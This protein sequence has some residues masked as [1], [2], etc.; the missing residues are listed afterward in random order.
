L[1][2]DDFNDRRI[3]HY[4]RITE[5]E[6]LRGT[7]L[8]ERLD[9]GDRG[10]GRAAREM[11]V[12]YGRPTIS[13]WGGRQ[14]DRGHYDY[15]DVSNDSLRDHGR[16]V[17]AEYEKPRVH[18]IPDWRA[19]EDPYHA[20]PLD[21]TLNESAL[22]RLDPP[23]EDWWPTEHYDRGPGRMVQLL[24]HQQAF[25]RRDQGV[26]FAL[27]TNF[28]AADFPGGAGDTLRG[29]LIFSTGPDSL[30]RVGKGVVVGYGAPFREVIESRPQMVGLE[31]LSRRPGGPVARTRFGIQPP[32]SLT[33][34]RPGERGIS[35][36]A[37]V[38]AVE[39]AIPSGNPD[40]A[41]ARMH[42]TTA[43]TDLA[44][45]GLYWETYGIATG[46]T[47]DVAI[48][49][50]RLSDDGLAR[51]IAVR[52]GLADRKDGGVTVHW[53]EP[54]SGYGAW[55]RDGR[56]PIQGREVF[57]NTSR[58][59]AGQYAVTVSVTPLRGAPLE[60]TRRFT[61]LPKAKR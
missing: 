41:L 33:G 5:V 29:A 59:D 34:M 24:D 23:V 47:V 19:I 53:R 26:L 25:F 42:G 36:I 2:V 43:F 46:D 40:V 12:R 13:Q 20:A 4:S 45:F 54:S 6:L 9:L 14:N 60:S 18:S 50:S 52:I 7:G 38:E 48:S 11:L 28:Y 57:L 10:G 30:R 51:R 55:V 22:R 31:M 44:R 21:W 39:G 56:V 17:T 58:L 35:D 49:V 3:A 1:W 32:P 61:I 16:F 15:L 8:N 27:S 37:L